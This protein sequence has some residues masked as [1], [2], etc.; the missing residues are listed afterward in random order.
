ML[1]SEECDLV[2]DHA[3]LPEHLPDYV[4]SV[5][6]GEPYLEGGH[7]CFLREKH[8][9]FIGYALG[10]GALDTPEAYESACRRF[11]PATVA[12]I[13]SEIPLPAEACET[14]GTDH[15]YRLDLPAV[16][17]PPE[18]AYMVRRADRELKVG[19]GTFGREHRKLVK[20]FLSQHDFASEQKHIYKRIPQYLNSSGTA[21]LI[22]ARKGHTLV[23]FNI[24]DTGA[25]GYAFYMFSFRS[26]RQ[27]VPGASDLI[28]SE[29][30][31]RAQSEGK[32]ALNLG[33]AINPGIQ[34]FKEKWG[35]KVFLPYA[36]AL[37]RRR[38]MN[39]GRLAD[40]L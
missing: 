37:V 36:S 38:A 22:E 14:R 21:S 18:V 30:I 9:T 16:S 26:Y 35:G 10:S 8:L 15:Y 12:L 25:R 4:R 6:G 19:T 17:P 13:A 1:T 11:K 23:A 32:K 29:M 31:R 40:K 34:R 5:T 39:L 2:Y 3:Y 24:L 7:L 33:L 27:P 28:F 20:A